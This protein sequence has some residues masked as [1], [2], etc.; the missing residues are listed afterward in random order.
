M[1]EFAVTTGDSVPTSTAEPLLSPLV[2]TMAVKLPAVV[3]FLENVTVSDVAVAAV[4]F[5]IAPLLKTTELFAGVGSKPKPSITIVLALAAIE[6]SLVVTIGVTVATWT[7]DWLA[8][9][10]V[11]TVAVKLPA[12]VGFVENVTTN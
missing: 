9:L 6:S 10:L 2:V 3:G 11:V 5:P 12:V 8:I 7:G 1:P 4:T